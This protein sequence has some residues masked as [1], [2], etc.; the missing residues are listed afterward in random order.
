MLGLEDIKSMCKIFIKIKALPLL[1]RKTMLKNGLLIATMFC[2]SK[3]SV[4]FL[5]TQKQNYIIK[6]INEIGEK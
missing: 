2:T 5:V 4:Y 1:K 6:V 3:D